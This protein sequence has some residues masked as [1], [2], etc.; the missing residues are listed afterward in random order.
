[1]L[2]SVVFLSL[3][4]WLCLGWELSRETHRDR[5]RHR[6]TERDR[7]RHRETERD[8]KRQKETE[9]W[10]LL[11]VLVCRV[12]TPRSLDQPHVGPFQYHPAGNDLVTSAEANDYCDFIA[13]AQLTHLISRDDAE[14]RQNAHVVPEVPMP[15]APIVHDAATP[16]RMIGGRC[17]KWCISAQRASG[18]RKC[19]ACSMCGTRF[20]QGKHVSNSGAT[21]KPT[22]ITY[23]HIVSMDH[24]LLPKLAD[25][26]EAVDAVARQWDTITRTA[27][28]TEVSL[29]FDQDPDQ[30][31]T[32]ARLDDERDLF[33]REEALRMDEEIMDFLL[34]E[35]V[36]WDSIVP[37]A[38]HDVWP[39][40]HEV[41][42]GVA[43][44]PTRHS[45]SHHAQQLHLSG[46]RVSFGKRWCSAAGFFWDGPLSTPLTA[47][48][49]TFRIRDW[50]LF[51]LRIGLL[52]GP[53][54]VPNVMLLQCR[55]RRAERTSSRCSHVFAKPH[56]RVLVKKD[57]AWQLPEMRPQFQSR[58][59]LSK[60]SR[61]STLLT[62]NSQLLRKRSCR[63][64]SCVKW[65]SMSLPHSERCHDSVNQDHLACVRNIGMISAPWRVTA[66][67]LCK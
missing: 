14:Q 43:A 50:S 3:W 1:M 21:V 51:G 27:A 15:G 8:R 23:M 5:E 4:L 35:H 2:P 64:Y 65:P 46:L 10:R 18:N 29:P 38:W 60:R 19:V 22:N 34:F 37:L 47:T 11:H 58:S 56:W 32:V 13:E 7:E 26:Q 16:R 42:F 33:G 12:Q 17:C 36:T 59:R 45:P 24:E 49:H 57:E 61:V 66:T 52:S 48:A 55:T 30:A 39:T 63:V 6:E 20:N 28:D 9:R 25:D 44:S 54:Y 53:W 40:S 41:Q 62:H 31:S 67:C